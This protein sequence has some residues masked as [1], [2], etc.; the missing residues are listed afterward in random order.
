RAGAGLVYLGTGE[1]VAPQVLAAV[2]DALLTALPE[3]ESDRLADLLYSLVEGKQV[4]AIGPGAGKASWLNTA[5][6][7]V[8]EKSP[9]LIIDADGLNALARDMDFY[10]KLLLSRRLRGLEPAIL[11]PHPGEFS[12]SRLIWTGPTARLPPPSWLLVW[13]ASCC[14]KELPLSSPTRT[15]GSG[16]TRRA[17]PGWPRRQRRC[18]VWLIAGLCA[19]GRSRPFE[20][21]AAG[22]T[23]MDWPRIWPRIW[24]PEE[25]APVLCF[26]GMCSGLLAGLLPPLDGKTDAPGGCHDT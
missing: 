19:Q 5:L 23:Y 2:A 24:L 16:S 7:M 14:S 13:T 10:Q 17:M 6:A 20:A 15:D 4:V 9:Q 18:P 12:A 21:A 1:S 25:R 22:A 3:N 11:T 26:Q 8:L